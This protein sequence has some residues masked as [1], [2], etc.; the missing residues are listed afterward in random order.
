VTRTSFRRLAFLA[1]LLL[2]GTLS[3]PASAAPADAAPPVPGDL[4]EVTSQ[5]SMEGMPMAMPARTQKLCAPKEWKEPPAGP[6]DDRQKCET[7]DFTNTPERT[8][9]KVRCSGKPAMTG[10]GEINRT[11]PDTYDGKIKMTSA[12]GVMTIS[13]KGKRLEDCDA[14]K[15]KH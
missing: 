15:G 9:W 6:M 4:W 2:L 10:E 1:V 8:T 3:G 5:M 13:L 7:L 12:D 11:G 14:S